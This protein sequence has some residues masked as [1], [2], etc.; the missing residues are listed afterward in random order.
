MSYTATRALPMEA[1]DA[2]SAPEAD[3]AGDQDALHTKLVRWFEEAESASYDERQLSERDRAY[4]DGDQWTGPEREALR[5]RGQPEITINYCRRKISL[6]CGMERKARTD[7]KAFPRDPTE[8][9]RADA[10]TQALRFIGDDNDFSV[11][12]SSVYEN[13]LI[14]GF[15]GIEIGLEDDGKGGADITYAHIGWERIW[16]DPHARA[17]DFADARY[18]GLVIW[19]DRDQVEELYPDATDVIGDSFEHVSGAASYGD[20]PSSVTWTD[21]KRERCRV[22]QC[23]WIQRGTWWSATYSRAGILS[24]PQKS[25]FRDRRGKSACPLVLQSAYID[26][27]NRRYGMVRDLISEQDEINKRRSKALHLLS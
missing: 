2:A 19:M 9:E 15:G 25:R 3:Y 6:L 24:P 12:R 1:A 20:R 18:L 14:E 13:M 26:R 8:E 22:V 7:A 10:A 11:I 27:E 17:V 16:K 5:K 23:H 21:T 4:V